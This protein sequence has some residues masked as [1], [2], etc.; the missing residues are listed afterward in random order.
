MNENAYK[1]QHGFPF[2]E[3][4]DKMRRN[5]LTN[6]YSLLSKDQATLFLYEI[7][8]PAITKVLL[9]CCMSDENKQAI[10]EQICDYENPVEI[11]NSTRHKNRFEL[12][13][14]PI[15]LA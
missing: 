2:S 12:N 9:G 6:A 11:I 10:Q 3:D 14:E 4:T 8:K 5:M 7:P 13:F 1:T 15:I